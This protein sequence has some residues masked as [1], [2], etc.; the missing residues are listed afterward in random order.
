MSL[1]NIETHLSCENYATDATSLFR[2]YRLSVGEILP[3]CN[4][5]HSA[6]IY[7]AE[8]SLILE[9][10]CLPRRTVETGTLF[11]A[12]M[13]LHVSGTAA[14]QCHLIACLFAGEPPLCNKYSVTSLAR[15]VSSKSDG[16]ISPPRNLVSS[17]RSSIS[18]RCCPE[19]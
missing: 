12:P 7:V 5:R 19:P 13:N 18:F 16:R 9:W 15:E 11:L 2:Q 3:S 14:C 8:G 4:G 10:G 6:L 17:S 1:C